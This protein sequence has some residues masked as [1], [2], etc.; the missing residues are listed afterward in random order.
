MGVKTIVAPDP[1]ITLAAAKVNLN[2][3]DT[4]Q[5]TR[6]QSLIDAA[7]ELAR[8]Y[9]WIPIGEQTRELALDDFPA[10][11]IDVGPLVDSIESV[12]YVDGAGETQTVDSADYALDDY[13]DGG[14]CWVLPAA[15]VIWP[16]VGVDV[17]N[18]VKVRFVCGT[19]VPQLAI[20][21]MHVAIAYWFADREGVEAPKGLPPAATA[22]LDL[23]WV[24]QA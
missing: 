14:S 10:D 20:Q 13:T 1:V 12:T 11:A 6:I 24:P 3:T 2:V 21:A 16:V 17:A 4:A 5:D 8:K 9:A 18:A 15:N 23:C 19:N 7:H 22:L